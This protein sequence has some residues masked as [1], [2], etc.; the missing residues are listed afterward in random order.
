MLHF[1]L[2]KKLERKLNILN[3]KNKILFLIYRKKMKE[4][5]S[6]NSKSIN[7]YKNLKSPMNEFKRIHLTSNFVLLF[8]VTKEKKHILF[9]EILH[10]DKAY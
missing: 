2:S 7:T 9:V 5:I 8:K 1:E 6:H 4:I 3:K 10:W